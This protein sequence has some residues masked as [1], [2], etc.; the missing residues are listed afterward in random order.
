MNYSHYAVAL[1]ARLIHTQS[2]S[3]QE[4]SQTVKVGT[5]IPE[6]GRFPSPRETAHEILSI[7]PHRDGPNFEAAEVCTIRDEAKSL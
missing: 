6:A 2:T 5:S 7:S 3:K 4:I 1:L